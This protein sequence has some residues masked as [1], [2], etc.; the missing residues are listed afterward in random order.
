MDPNRTRNERTPCH[1]DQ[2]DAKEQHGSAFVAVLF[3][4]LVLTGLAYSSTII[5]GTEVKDSKR[6]MA[7]LRAVSVAESGFEKTVHHL[8]AAVKKTAFLDPFLGL[9]NLFDDGM[10]GYKTYGPFTD[11][12]VTD[13]TGTIGDFTA[14]VTAIDRAKG[15]DLT[16]T[17]TGYVPA[18]PGKLPAGSPPPEK[19]TL[20][21]TIRL[22]LLPSQVFDSGYF[23]NNWGWF[24]GS[25]IMSYGNARSNGQFDAANYSPTITGQPTY[26]DMQWVAGKADLL[27]YQDDN[28]DGKMDGKDG[29]IF[30]GFDIIRTQNVKGEGGKAINQHDFQDTVEMPNL[31]DLTMYEK[32]AVSSGGSIKIGGVVQSNAV[33]GDEPG[34]KGNIYLN[35]TAANPI[36]INGTVVIR[37]NVIITGV[38]KGQGAIYSSGNVY[39]P[40][41]ITYADP[42]ATSRPLDNTEA[43]TEKWISNNQTKDFLGLFAK[44]SIVAGDI[45]NPT[46]RNYVG[47]WLAHGMNQS[48]EDSG[49]DLVPNTK[50][51]KDGKFG[52]A[53]DDVLEGDGKFTI[54]KYTAKD[55]ALGL[56]PPGKV[57]GD[58]I[59][60]TGEDIDGDGK[61]DPTITLFD[62][63][64]PAALDTSNWGG[65][66]PALG[67]AKYSDIASMKMSQ[68]DGVF[69][70]N[71]AFA[72][73][74]LPGGGTDINLNGALV[75]RNESIIYEAKHLNF[76]H[77]ARLLGSASGIAG[78]MLP[79]TIAPVRVLS[80]IL[81]D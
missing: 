34:E 8:K 63:D 23:I 6:S 32:Q 45:T 5:A 58:P 1:Q 70:T 9:K 49:E 38:V 41:N 52:T 37:G 21:A 15:M 20:Q 47:K 46:W 77:D 71:H 69:Y 60:G 78:D 29:G 35:G 13:G 66:M 31:N 26:T 50:N 4:M 10:G 27:G 2:V 19:R 24:Y 81:I 22:E 16:I 33:Y 14:T 54:Q 74:A 59:P 11:E 67:I 62:L 40:N 42:P 68:M 57:I 64:L 48:K 43:E 17:S 53:D 36:E 44:E 73:T 65:N 72:W 61:Y 56:I 28:E 25:N 3:T 12:P 30:S 51:G 76:N 7:R 80:W 75:C 79:K 18:A 39:V 55:A